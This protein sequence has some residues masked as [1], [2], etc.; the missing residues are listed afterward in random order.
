MTRLESAII[1]HAFVRTVSSWAKRT[2]LPGFH[3]VSL[4]NV[5]RFFFREINNT[6]INMRAAAVTYNFLMAIPPTL[7]F[8]FAL[9]PYLPLGDVEQTIIDIID[10]LAPNPNI[11]RTFTNVFIDFM[12]NQHADLLSFGILMTIM[13]SSNGMMGLMNS[14]DRGLK[15]YVKRSAF[16]RR[17]TAIK[18]TLMTICVVIISLAALILQTEAVNDIILKIFNNV[19]AVKIFSGLILVG[20]VFSTISIIYS[21]GPSLTHRFRFVSPGSVFATV[22]S[23]LTTVVF[24]FLVNNLINYNKVYGSIGTLIAFMIWIWLI[25]MVLLLGYELNVSILLGKFEDASEEK[26]N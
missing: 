11:E 18:L 14:F 9:V 8:L 20:L 26:R 24:F 25:T 4:Y 19:I 16:K 1:N 3:G 5:A 21:Y 6:Q 13:F 7:L 22:M 2:V 15:V 10:L 23:L 17:W 12:N